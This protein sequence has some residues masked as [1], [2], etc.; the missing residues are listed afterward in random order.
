MPVQALF[1]ATVSTAKEL[2][3]AWAKDGTL[4]LTLD[5]AAPVGTKPMTFSELHGEL[6][7]LCP[8][9]LKLPVTIGFPT[10]IVESITLYHEFD[11]AASCDETLMLICTPPEE[12]FEYKQAA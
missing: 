4:L 9:Q 3:Y 7:S 5:C 8:W 11:R 12:Y 2:R 6:R 1:L 10:A